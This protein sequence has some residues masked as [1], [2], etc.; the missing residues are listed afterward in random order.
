MW[1]TLIGSASEWRI[2]YA[3]AAACGTVPEI[4]DRLVHRDHMVV[5][6]PRD[7]HGLRSARCCKMF[8]HG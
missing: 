1:K 3:A 2:V 4:S 5:L 8:S 6:S 7:G